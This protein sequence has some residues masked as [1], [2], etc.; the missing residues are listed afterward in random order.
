[1]D[2][3]IFFSDRIFFHPVPYPKNLKKYFFDKKSFKLW[4]W[5]HR[6]NVVKMT[7][8]TKEWGPI[9][10]SAKKPSQYENVE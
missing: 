8:T 6:N 5:I 1:M 2:N 3:F 7:S 10:M 9:G 4:I